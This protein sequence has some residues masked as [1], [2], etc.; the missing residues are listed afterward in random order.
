MEIGTSSPRLYHPHRTDQLTWVAHHGQVAYHLSRY[1][2]TPRLV[3][4][5]LIKAVLDASL[6]KP[7]AG[8]Q[9]SLQVLSLNESTT[10]GQT[11]LQVPKVLATG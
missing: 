10:I 3:V 9:V 2:R 11:T 6:G 1:V 7:A 5:Q 8:V 4:L